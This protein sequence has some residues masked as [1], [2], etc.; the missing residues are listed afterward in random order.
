MSCCPLGRDGGGNL[1]KMNIAFGL[2]LY[3]TC[4]P[5]CLPLPFTCLQSPLKLGCV[6]LLM[7]CDFNTKKVLFISNWLQL[8]DNTCYSQLQ[9]LELHNHHQVHISWITKTELLGFTVWH[10]VQPKTRIRV[11]T[12]ERERRLWVWFLFCV[13]NDP[14]VF[15]MAVIG[16]GSKYLTGF[17]ETDKDVLVKIVKL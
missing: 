5:P 14:K 9:D 1:R 2:P 11:G 12:E 4:N 3:F 13:L 6:K 10:N 15:A 17:K 8:L 16:G 7:E